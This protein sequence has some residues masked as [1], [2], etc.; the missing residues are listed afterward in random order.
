MTLLAYEDIQEAR[1]RPALDDRLVITPLLQPEQVGSASVD[2]RLGTEFLQLRR[3]SGAGLD[4]KK[5]PQGVVEEM[6]ER[7]VVPL[8]EGLWLHPRHFVLAATFEY[9]RLPSDIGAYVVGRSSWGRVG[10]IVATAVMAHP[11]FTGCL[12]LELV[13]EGDSPI[14]LYPGTRIAQLAFHRTDTATEHT[15]GEKDK[16]FAPIGPEASRLAREEPQ[17][18]RVEELANALRSRLV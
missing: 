9:L 14:C 10:L 6:L 18:R 16:Y 12:T 3:T 15:Y 4:P 5:Q 8:G 11:G 2:V 1:S 17:I 7:L 13:N